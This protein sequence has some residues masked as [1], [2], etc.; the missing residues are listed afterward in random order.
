MEQQDTISSIRQDSAAYSNAV[1]VDNTSI[2]YGHTLKRIHEKPIINSHS[3]SYWEIVILFLIFCMYVL[4]RIAEPK[5]IGKMFIAVF[6]MQEAKQ[7]FRQEFRLT[8][9]ISL[10]LV[11]AFIFILAFFM[12]FM[13]QYYGFVLINSTHLLQY[14]FFVLVITL[15]FLLKFVAVYVFAFISSNIEL[16]KEY[17]FNVL[18]FSQTIGIILFPLMTCIQYTK[19]PPQWF[20]FPSAIIYIGFYLLRAY[21]TIIISAVEQNIGILYIILYL[22]ALEILPLL[23]LIKFLLVNF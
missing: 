21:R 16:G 20:L 5:K 7:L 18:I 9:R 13:N 12:Q 22:C 6:S 10:L 3:P 14:F 17:L 4:I 2:F 15:A 19:F 11:I 23:V 1:S 8:K